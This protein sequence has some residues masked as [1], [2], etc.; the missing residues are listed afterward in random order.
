MTHYNP[1]FSSAGWRVTLTLLALVWLSAVA[2]AA[3]D[4]ERVV[5]HA[6]TQLGTADGWHGEGDVRI[7]YQDIDIRCDM[8]DWNRATGEVVASGNV[9]LDRGPSRFTADDA[10]FNIQ[11]KTGTFFNATAFIDPM[12]TFTGREIEKIDET[13]YR[14]D[15]ATF[16]TCAT[17]GRPPWSFHVRKAKVEQEGLGRFS[18]SAMKVRG[19]PVFYMPYM[20][21]PI[22][23]ERAAGLLF[24]RFGYSNTRGFNFG[25]PLFIPIGRSYDT[26]IFADYYA[27]GY[28]GLGNSWRWAPAAGARG[29]INLY[30]IWDRENEEAQWKVFGRHA[31]ENFLGFRLLAQVEDMSDIDFWQEF[32]RSFAANTR[33]DLYS[34]A[35]LTRSFGPY[36]LNL[37][38]DQR[39]T[40]L[41]NADVNLTQLPEIEI[42]SGSTAIGG[43]PVY[44]NLIGSLN[45]FNVD[46]DFHYPDVADLVG[47]YGRADLFPQFSYTLPGPP[48]ISVTPRIGGRFTYYTD[49]YTEDRREFAGEPINRIYATGAV[50]IVGPSLSKVFKGGIGAYSKIKH[51][52]EPRFEYRYLTTTTD[53]TR[54]PVFDEVDSTPQDA[55]LVNFVLANRLLGR[56]RD[57]VGTRELGSLELIQAYSFDAPLNR[58]DGVNTSQL[59]P[60]G[61]ALRLTPTQGTG[62]DARLSYDLLYKNLR[63][64]SLAASLM[65][66]L[67]MLNLTWYES[68][69]ARTGDRFSSQVRS[70]VAFR[71]T[72]FPL[73]ASFQIAYDIVSDSIGDQRYQINYQGSCWNISAQYRDTRIG[74]FPT[75]EI[76]LVIGLKGVGALPEI[77]GSLGG[78]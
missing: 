62:F 74:A 42:R 57:G 2:G 32:D 37:R 33:R 73:D 14:I 40:F 46:R 48:W 55:N 43:S 17:D 61:M 29:D 39:K 34:F 6:E 19:V 58:G 36:S 16:T 23:Q 26:T 24:P 13:H 31:Q 54:I 67:G 65:R 38:A 66:P 9:I 77:K 71:K 75:R 27:K 72:G 49:Q 47:D 3:D 1:T 52:I 5:L 20:V 12:Y 59:G 68:Y 56:A 7:V 50:D 25:L 21:W 11:T 45:Y 70:L 30:A 15:R 53:V 69:S 60:L 8:A 35:F 78:Y 22:K 63:S 28:F 44:L 41:T 18:S 64:T 76:L 4:E 10:R 51:L